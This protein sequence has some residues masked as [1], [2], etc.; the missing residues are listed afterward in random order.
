M[1]NKRHVNI[2][3]KGVKDWNAWL[4]EHPD[5]APDLS[6]ISLA[7]ADLMHVDLRGADL[8]GADLQETILKWANLTN[9]NLEGA[10]LRNAALRGADVRGASLRHANLEEADLRGANLG[11]A[12]FDETNLRGVVLF[13]TFLSDIDLSTARGLDTCSHIGPCTVDHR[14]IARSKNTPLV[15]WRGCGLPDAL[16]DYTPS[17]TSDAV[18]FYSCFVSYSSK[19]QEF[20]DRL[21]ADLQNAGVR[22]WFAPHDLTIGA[23]TWDGIDE[24]IRTR[25]KVLLILSEGALD[26]EWVEDEVTKAF[27]E[28]RRREELVLFPVRLDD[29]VI[30]S[31]EPWAGKLRDN[32]NIGD[33]T[34]W[35]KH[36][37]YKETF[38]RVLR[39]LKAKQ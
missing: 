8:A 38:E 4:V 13:E 28:E 1:A 22:C 25:D 7:R 27:A 2:L 18:Q 30:E 33:F 31:K 32:R 39:D 29:A 17:L 23:K 20:A 11:W 3:K 19:D 5:V 15:F 36:E 14:T 10:N 37:A 34:H 26:S 21:Y 9:A 12:D 24:A 6:G 16:I 35:K